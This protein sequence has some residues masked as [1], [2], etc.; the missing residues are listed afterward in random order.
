M[1]TPPQFLSSMTPLVTQYDSFIV[2]LWGVIHDGQEL[3]TGVEETLLEIQQQNKQLIFLSN[4]PYRANNVVLLLE[5]LGI[6][7]DLYECIVTSGETFWQTLASPEKH[8]FFTPSGNHFFFLGNSS[9]FG[10]MQGLNYIQTHDVA[11]ADFM[12]ILDYYEDQHSLSG[13][14]QAFEI[15]VRRKIPL[16]CVNPDKKVVTMQG[17]VVYCSGIIAEKYQEMGGEVIYFGKP[18]PAVYQACL[19]SI[20][21][22]NR[23]IAI[24]DGLETD[25]KGAN[26]QH[27]PSV[28]VTS[29]ITQQHTGKPGSATYQT[30]CLALFERENIQPDYVLGGFR[31]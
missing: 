4:A 31:L 5:Q 17:K 7:S 1:Q 16:I 12:L 18:Y 29:G 13:I 21:G 9:D 19:A 20:P 24:G 3:Y 8:P 23:I 22:S 10:F 14:M 2:D 25:I 27:I 11:K 6:S 28:L 30:N 26:S 15:A